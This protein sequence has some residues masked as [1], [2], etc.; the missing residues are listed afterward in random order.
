MVGAEA[1]VSEHRGSSAIAASEI[2]FL[3][4]LHFPTTSSSSKRGNKPISAPISDFPSSDSIVDRLTG[5]YEDFTANHFVEQLSAFIEKFCKRLYSIPVDETT[6]IDSVLFNHIKAFKLSFSQ[7]KV[8]ISFYLDFDEASD[9]SLFIRL[10]FAHQISSLFPSSI[11][12]L[13]QQSYTGFLDLIRAMQDNIDGDIFS[14]AISRSIDTSA[15]LPTTTVKSKYGKSDMKAPGKSSVSVSS[16]EEQEMARKAIE[17]S[18]IADEERSKLKK[19][20]EAE[21]KQAK[22]VANNIINDIG[23]N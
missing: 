6:V 14:R 22:K 12:S 18:L 23:S 5:L 11:S 8:F 7:G 20:K 4:K 1:L 9:P 3:N 21:K 10:P 15:S 19:Q 17:D 2:L 16:S 13:V